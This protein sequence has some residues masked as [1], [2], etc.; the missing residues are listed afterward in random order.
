MSNTFGWN[1]SPRF[2]PEQQSLLL[3]CAEALHAY[4]EVILPGRGKEWM[5]RWL[6]PVRFHL[7]GLP[8]WLV[9]RAAGHPLSV[10]FPRRDVWLSPGFNQLPDPRQHVLHELA[11]VLD[12]TQAA[13]VLPATITGK[14]PADRLMQS[15]GGLPRGMRFSNGLCGLPLVNQWPA[16]INDG[17]GNH[18]SAEYFAEAFAW[19]VI[20]PPLLPSPLV[21]DWLKVNVFLAV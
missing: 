11:H 9:S 3:E 8:Q 19:S 13:R 10:V 17:Y 2:T 15:L 20:H 5:T 18:A 7:G 6:S 16:A 21:V 14:G 1:T 12:N 4:A